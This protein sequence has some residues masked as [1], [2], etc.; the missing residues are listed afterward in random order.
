[1]K[2]IRPLLLF[3][4][5]FT[6]LCAPLLLL[7]Q[8]PVSGP[9][10]V[11]SGPAAEPL[12][13][14]GV[15]AVVGAV[16]ILARVFVLLTPTPTDDNWYRSLIAALKKLGLH[17][18]C[19]ISAL[20]ILPLMGCA[21]VRSTQTDTSQNERTITTRVTGYTLFSSAQTL[22]KLTATTTDKTQSFGLAGFSQQGATNAPGTISEGTHFL[23]ALAKM[24][25]R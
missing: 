16:V 20:C 2:T 24:M 18:P 1:M 7:A 15:V 21:V 14:P 9:S 12:T 6:S 17:L 3:I 25:G 19:L 8:E 5:L 23:E 22:Q 13:F 11:V 4:V 10:S